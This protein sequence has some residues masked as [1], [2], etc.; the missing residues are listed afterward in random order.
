MKYLVATLPEMVHDPSV[1]PGSHIEN[2][3]FGFIVFSRSHRFA[4]PVS[5]PSQ[6]TRPTLPPMLSMAMQRRS[7]TRS[8]LMLWGVFAQHVHRGVMCMMLSR[9]CLRVW[10]KECGFRIL[11]QRKQKRFRN[12][13]QSSSVLVKWF[14]E[15][16]EHVENCSCVAEIGHALPSMFAHTWSNTIIHFDGVLRD[17]ERKGDHCPVFT[18][19]ANNPN[20]LFS[21]KHIDNIRLQ[22]VSN[23]A[24]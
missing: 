10:R 3:C 11:R 9:S 18:N 24:E 4:W 1:G 19:K 7:L 14:F 13:S 20:R 22:P 21:S 23:G 15:S 5:V 12:Y 16:H 6:Q 17:G 8:K 2:L